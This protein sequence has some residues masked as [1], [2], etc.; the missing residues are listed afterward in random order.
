MVDNAR[1]VWLSNLTVLSSSSAECR[2]CSD[3]ELLR[4]YCSG[5]WVAV[6]RILAA[7]E[8]PQLS[9]T[10]LTIHASRVV[11]QRAPLFKPT[12]SPDDGGN[13]LG[14]YVGKVRVIIRGILRLI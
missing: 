5:D 10:A 2:P 9:T 7:E 1:I 6:G 12:S 8:L 3:E 13:D 14:G 11:Q 4:Q